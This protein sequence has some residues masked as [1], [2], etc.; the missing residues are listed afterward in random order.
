[1]RFAAEVQCLGR[2]AGGD[3]VPAAAAAAHEIERGELARHDVGL[4]EAGRGGADE[5]DILGV[6]G[7][8]REHGERLD[9]GDVMQ[10]VQAGL[11]GGIDRM[12]VGAEH[13]VDQPTLGGFRKFDHAREI[14]AGVFVALRVPP[15]RDVVTARPDEH[16]DLE[17]ALACA[18]GLA[19]PFR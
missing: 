3:H 17:L 7:E 10:P 2:V 8:R 14:G 15:R 13:H 11:L 16:P 4:L 5:A 19:L 12:G 1:V 6:T 18:H 9:P